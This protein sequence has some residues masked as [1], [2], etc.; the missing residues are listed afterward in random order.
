MIELDANC[1]E[2][3]IQDT[4]PFT[5]FGKFSWK[6]EMAKVREKSEA[7]APGTS[8]DSLRERL[9]KKFPEYAEAVESEREA[10][11]FCLAI[12]QELR[13]RRKQKKLDQAEMAELMDLTQ[14]AVSKLERGRGDIG[15]KSIY[16]YAATLGLQPI[17]VFA[18]LSEEMVEAVMG[19]MEEDSVSAETIHEAAADITAAQTR[20]VQSFSDDLVSMM[21]R[22]TDLTR[23]V[24]HGPHSTES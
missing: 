13:R 15:L 1:N 9:A 2:F 10:E 3:R 12:R 6:W 23:R 16:R 7:T 18:P 5:E 8:V 22:Y 14:S 4:R 19:E 17:V 24:R 21:T 11:E 20:I